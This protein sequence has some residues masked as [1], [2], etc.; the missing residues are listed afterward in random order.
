MNYRK[1]TF[2]SIFFITSLSF[3]QQSSA[4]PKLIDNF[5]KKGNE[6]GGRSS[7]YMKEPSGIVARRTDRD[8]H[9]E[10]GQSLFL[11]YKKATEGGPFGKGGWCGYFTVIKQGPRQYFDASAYQYIT[12]WVKGDKG[13]ENFKVGVADATWDQREDSMKSEEIGV[14]LEAKKITTEWQQAR[15]PLEDFWVDTSKLASIAICF[16]TE[17]FPEGGGKGTIYID[18]LYFE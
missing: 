8:H 6:F 5:E 17:C 16:E 12:F 1:L 10:S 14:Y 7:T 11:G 4:E 13:G 2:L 18:D 15:I 9:G 3:A